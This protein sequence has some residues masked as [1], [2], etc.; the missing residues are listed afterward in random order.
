[1][2]FIYKYCVYFLT[3]YITSNIGYI[4]C[5]S[6]NDTN[7]LL[8]NLLDGYNKNVRPVENQTNAVHVNAT[9]VLVTIQ[10]LDEI[11]GILS[12]MG[13]MSMQWYDA[14]MV[15]DPLAYGDVEYVMTSYKEV[16]VPELILINPADESDTLGKKW[17]RV[18]FNYFGFA[19]WWPVDLIKSTCTLDV[20]RYPFDTQECGLSFSAWGYFSGQVKLNPSS[21]EIDL[22][23]YIESFTWTLAKSQVRSSAD[24]TALEFILH[25]KRKPDFVIV[26]VLLPLTFLSL[27]N[28]LVFLLLP[29]SGERISYCIT[30]LLSIAV[31]MTIVSDTLPKSSEPVPVIS[32]KL[33][34]DMITSAL[35]TLVTILNLRVY[36]RNDGQNVPNWLKQ[37]YIFVTCKRAKNGIH[38]NSTD[39]EKIKPDRKLSMFDNNKKTLMWKRSNDDE[40]N[41]SQT[42]FNRKMSAISVFNV[43]ENVHEPVENTLVRMMSEAEENSFDHVDVSWKNISNMIDGI[44][45]VFFTLMSVCSFIVFFAITF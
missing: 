39:V 13:I 1:M 30:V 2:G 12:V 14:S 24:G 11:R 33:M 17:Q 41:N 18:F 10:D 36:Y 6:I 25:L 5:A 20:Y 23:Y 38:R 29:E 35:M 7:V 32:Y 22:S 26:N 45:F 37:L 27:L 9:F 3:L 44:A 31:F 34:V 8:R 16:W 19:S 43:E 40:S 21:N 28:A 42:L 15:W 4:H